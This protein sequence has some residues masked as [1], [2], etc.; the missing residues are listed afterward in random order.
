MLHLSEKTN[1][2][3][4]VLMMSR[5]QKP[6]G[7]TIISCLMV[8]RK[9]SRGW[10]VCPATSR[11]SSN[12]QN[13]KLK[14]YKSPSGILLNPSSANLWTKTPFKTNFLSLD[15]IR[16]N[17]ALTLGQFC[18]LKTWQFMLRRRAA[19]N[20]TTCSLQTTWTS[21][22]THR[23]SVLKIKPSTSIWAPTVLR[24]RLNIY[25]WKIKRNKI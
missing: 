7:K 3:H 16:R 8:P 1:Q 5:R 6:T 15:R 24:D 12:R 2:I 23:P 11:L 17:S 10:G 4:S 13:R 22:S 14:S 9:D 18:S 25:V 20:R 19:L 21:T